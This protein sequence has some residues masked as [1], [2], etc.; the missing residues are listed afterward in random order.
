MILDI[1]TA[2]NP[3]RT[4]Y[5]AHDLDIQGPVSRIMKDKDS[6]EADFGEISYLNEY[7]D[8]T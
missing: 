5:I 1:G 4:D 7:R 8:F 2:N 3:P 6:G